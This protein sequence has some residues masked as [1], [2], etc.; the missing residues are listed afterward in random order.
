MNY[1]EMSDFEINRAVFMATGID[2]EDISDVPIGGGSAIAF[3]DGCKWREYDYC[4]NPAD[5]WPLIV[6]N[7]IA[8]LPYGRN[9][10]WMVSAKG[11]RY[12]HTNPLRAA[13]IVY[14]MMKERD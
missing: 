11:C 1:A 5:M 7:E 8:T 13:A 9:S 14:L 6:E 4:N 10:L 3:G 12:H 2:Y